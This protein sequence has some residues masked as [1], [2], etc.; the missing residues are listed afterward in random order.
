MVKLKTVV[1]HQEERAEKSKSKKQTK[2]GELDCLT[3]E[4]A[5]PVPVQGDI[6]MECSEVSL[7]TNNLNI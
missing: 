2:G 7:S 6:K 3:F 1:H 4:L 5:S